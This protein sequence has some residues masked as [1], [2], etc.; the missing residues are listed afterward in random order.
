M[1]TAMPKSIRLKIAIR[2]VSSHPQD[3]KTL[4]RYMFTTHTLTHALHAYIHT[5]IYY[6]SSAKSPE[7]HSKYVNYEHKHSSIFKN[8]VEREISEDDIT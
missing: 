2:N 5:K 1:N 4:Y 6:C 3:C 7:M 8:Y